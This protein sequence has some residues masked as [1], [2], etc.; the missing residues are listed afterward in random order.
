MEQTAP[1]TV[2]VH[3]AQSLEQMERMA[4]LLSQSGFFK[5]AKDVAKAFVKIQAGKELG[6]P[7]VASMRG[8]DV[9]D[10]NISLRAHLMASM[11]K[12][13]GRYRYKILEHTT[14]IC[15]LAFFEQIDG[16]WELAGQWEF[17][18]E[19]AKKA[20]LDS[21]QPWKAYPKAMLYNRA[22][23]EGGRYYCADLFFGAVY[24][25]DEL[26]ELPTRS[27]EADPIGDYLDERE[28]AFDIFN[29]GI[30][31]FQ[32]P[33]GRLR[34][35]FEPLGVTDRSKL[36]LEQLLEA[37]DHM[38][39]YG[40]D[41][42]SKNQED[43]QSLDATAH[44]K[45]EQL[46]TLGEHSE[47]SE[48]MSMFEPNVPPHEV[49]WTW[50]MCEATGPAAERRRQLLL[51]VATDVLLADLK[52]AESLSEV[53]WLTCW[54]LLLYLCDYVQTPEF[55]AFSIEK[56]RL[57]AL[58]KAKREWVKTQHVVTAGGQA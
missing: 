25:V 40:P 4:R 39:R 55:A 14:T 15:R 6:L 37:I 46:E 2:A 47:G 17:T 26:E 20:N 56:H 10:G 52:T 35:Y 27:G 29:K 36:T 42:F 7:P 57:E 21:R 23:A 30:E 28:Q 33:H 16:A 32:I 22:M 5:D 1:T 19:Q 3:E 51:H 58:Q 48:D 38:Q 53:D 24:D 31:Q 43:L 18:I 9:I 13:S 8:I 34:A 12:S 44:A 41:A 11:I 49:A 50:A 54:D 45:P